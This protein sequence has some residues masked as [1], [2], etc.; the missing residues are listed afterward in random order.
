MD[1][2]AGLTHGHYTLQLHGD[3]VGGGAVATDSLWFAPHANVV[4]GVFNDSALLEGLQHLLKR[5]AAP[6]PAGGGADSGSGSSSSD[7]GSGSG[8]GSSSGGGGR[9]LT[10]DFLVGSTAGWQIRHMRRYLGSPLWGGDASWRRRTA[11]VLSV[12]VW[13]AKHIRPA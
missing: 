2:A 1:A 5:T 12:C 11:L 4:P 13:E 3:D 6:G 7:G 8:G 10:L 9:R